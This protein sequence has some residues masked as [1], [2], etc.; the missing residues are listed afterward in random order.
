[1]GLVWGVVVV[2][3][4]C[5]SGRSGSGWVSCL[6]GLG[7]FEVFSLVSS[8][9]DLCWVGGVVTFRF[10]F[11]L[12]CVVFLLVRVVPG[13]GGFLF[14]VYFVFWFFSCFLFFSSLFLFGF[15]S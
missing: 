8:G 9:W 13:F 1:V 4:G 14:F 6:G 2:A 5:V 7:G 10:F 12:F 15:L 11:F 3:S